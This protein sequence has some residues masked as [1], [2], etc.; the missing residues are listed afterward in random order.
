MKNKTAQEY[1]SMVQ[2]A[3]PHSPVFRDC[4]L[5]FLF[6]GGICTFGQILANLYMFWGL[7]QKDARTC[8]SITLIFMSAA[9]TA[10]GV[11]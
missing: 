4:L 9:L 5:A 2:K 6:G 11:Y 1:D 7:E 3:S 10:F 8:V